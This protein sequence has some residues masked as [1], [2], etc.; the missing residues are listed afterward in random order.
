MACCG[1]WT[2]GPPRRGSLLRVADTRSTAPREVEVGVLPRCG[3][4]EVDSRS[5][6]LRE[7]VAGGG[8]KVHQRQRMM[9]RWLDSMNWESSV[10]SGRGGRFSRIWATD[11]LTLRLLR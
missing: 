6:A 4:R 5:I 9:P 10:S 2:Q 3:S 1:R 8:H 7:C 11:C